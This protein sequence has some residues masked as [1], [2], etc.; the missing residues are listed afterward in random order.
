MAPP[1]DLRIP[2]DATYAP[3]SLLDVMAVAPLASRILLGATVPGRVIQLAAMG[4][5]ARSV[6]KDW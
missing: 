6:V 1:D 5:Y 4:L 2:N 3:V